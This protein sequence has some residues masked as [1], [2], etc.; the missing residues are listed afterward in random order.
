MVS[1]CISTAL[2]LRALL[3]A[4]L[5]DA[6][7]GPRLAAAPFA[8]LHASSAVQAA[9]VP[10]PP[11]PVTSRP[12]SGPDQQQGQPNGARDACLGGGGGGA[13]GALQRYPP[14]GVLPFRGLALLAAPLFYLYDNPALAYR[15]FRSMYCRYG[16][17]YCGKLCA[18]GG[19]EGS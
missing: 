11:K 1:H 10:S 2:P 16:T 18:Q 14:C 19:T 6:A 12:S 3:L 5:R 8:P 9:V 17:R 7:V 15:L 13:A 4:F